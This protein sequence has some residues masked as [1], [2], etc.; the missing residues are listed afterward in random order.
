M[1]RSKG[2]Q[3]TLTARQI[4]ERSARYGKGESYGVPYRTLTPKGLRN[5]LVAGRS[6]SA[7]R[8]VQASVRIMPACMTT[9]EAAGVAAKLALSTGDVHSISTDTLREIL[10][11]RNAYIH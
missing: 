5:V 8:A 4:E 11:S 6:I 9:G 2:E 10:I 3:K 7:D 1:H